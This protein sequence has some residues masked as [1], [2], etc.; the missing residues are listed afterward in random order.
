MKQSSMNLFIA[1]A[2]Y[3]F[4]IFF[5]DILLAHTLSKND[6]GIWKH[7]LLLVNL[8]ALVLL[9]LPQGFNYFANLEKSL[10]RHHL[11]NVLAAIT[12][13]S[14]I[15]F[16][17]LVLGLN[18]LIGHALNDNF[19]IGAAFIY[20][21]IIIATGLY[22]I[23]EMLSVIDKRTKLLPKANT[24]FSI[25]YMIACSCIA[26]Y[27]FRNGLEPSNLSIAIIVSL[28]TAHLIRTGYVFTSLKI[29]FRTSD[30][31][32][33]KIRKYLKYGIPIYL[34]TF[35]GILNNYIDQIIVS[36]FESLATFGVY[37]VGAKG[38]PLIPA[39]SV[40]VAQSIFPQ[41]MNY[42]NSGQNEKAQQLWLKASVK[43]SYL[44]Y[45]IIIVLM[46]LAPYLIRYIYGEDFNGAIE[47]FQTYLIILVFR[48]NGYGR[49]LMIRDEN[50]WLMLFMI[51]AFITNI[52]VSLFLYNRIGIIGVVWGTILATSVNVFLILT[53]ERL[54]FRYLK[55]FFIDNFVLG[56][57]VIFLILSVIYN[58]F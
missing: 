16:I 14:S 18:K 53:K 47:V 5:I 9:G 37:A 1:Q 44:L 28:F 56:L 41:L 52:F 36:N 33:T 48:H 43:A 13:V 11:N 8:S 39:M 15:F 17:A 10:K 2:I 46:V 49:L 30:I 26:Y 34:A 50:K 45:P 24:F 58:W 57:M 42:Q 32:F 21:F 12:I 31:D 3:T 40:I 4:T 25:L 20:P 38:F 51:C 19:I 29:K 55:A 22:N 27:Y 6:F 23:L 7:I 54:L 35:I